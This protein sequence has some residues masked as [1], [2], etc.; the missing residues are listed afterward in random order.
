MSYGLIKEQIVQARIVAPLNI[1]QDMGLWAANRIVVNPGVVE[2]NVDIAPP[3][4]PT[5][6]FLKYF[7][8]SPAKWIMEY[9]GEDVAGIE[10]LDTASYGNIEILVAFN[11]E[12]GPPVDNPFNL[13]L[14]RASIAC[15]FY[16]DGSVDV[17]WST[18]LEKR[19]SLT[20]EGAVV[21]KGLCDSIR[22]GSLQED[23]HIFPTESYDDI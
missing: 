11:I 23:V 13:S 20:G 18:G 21:L 6:M 12:D 5:L 16:E 4:F 17:Y 8:N 7:V 9:T 15:W 1:D 19:R 14:R 2:T 3:S 10:H 22:S